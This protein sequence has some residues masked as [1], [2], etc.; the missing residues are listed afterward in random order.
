MLLA[1]DLRLVH[2]SALRLSLLPSAC[3]CFVRPL[4]PNAFFL[5]SP[6]IIPHHSSASCFVSLP[7]WHSHYPSSPLCLCLL[8]SFCAGRTLFDFL[9][10][11]SP[12]FVRP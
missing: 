12:P 9:A 4:P 5:A 11:P 3:C 10:K 6:T 2:L 8:A 1:I 7:P